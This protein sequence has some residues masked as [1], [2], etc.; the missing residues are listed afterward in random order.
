MPVH[1]RSIT[2]K[3]DYEVE[4]VIR[5]LVVA[6]NRQ[7]AD[8]SVIVEEVRP[9][10]TQLATTVGS[11]G[12]LARVSKVQSDQITSIITQVEIN[13]LLSY[14]RA[15]VN[16]TFEEPFDAVVTSD[17]AT[18]TMSIEQ[19]GGGD[20]NMQFSDGITAFDTTPPATIALTTGSD[21]SPTENYI[22]IPQS[23]KV[24]T[25]STSDWPTAEH[26]KVGF[27]LV[28]S[29]GFVQTNGVYIN[30]NWNDPIKGTTEQGHITHMAERSR[31]LG[32]VY[33]SG[34]AGNG[35]DGYLTPAAGNTE[36]LATAGE[37][38]Q[39]H[40]HTV[41]AFDTSGGDQVLVKNWN[42]DAYH[43]I[44]NLFDI[45]ADSTGAAIGNNKYFNLVIW[46]VAN[47]SGEY[48]PM[49]INL[50]AGSYNTQSG[51]EN[52][53]SGFDDFS[54]PGSFD[55]ESSTGFLIARITIQMGATWSVVSTVDLR[56]SNPQSASGGASGVSTEFADNTFKIFDEGDV[57]KIIQF[58]ASGITAG[59]TRTATMPD[60]DITLVDDAVVL[61]KDGSVALTAPWDAGA[62]EIRAE[63]FESDVATGTPPFVVA[64]TT[65]VSNLNVDLLDGLEETA[66]ALLAGRAGGQT[67]IGGTGSGDDLVLQSTSHGTKG[68]IILEDA[69]LITF[70]ATGAILAFRDFV[71]DNNSVRDVFFVVRDYSPGNG[72]NGIGSRIVFQSINDAGARV[73]IGKFGAV[74][75][76]AAAGSE[77][78]DFIMQN[79]NAA[80][81]IRASHDRN[82]MIAG[83]P[84]PATGTA[85]IV[86][87][88]GTA[89][90]NMG[91]NTA[92]LYANDD[93]GTVFMYAIDDTNTAVQLSSHN[94]RLFDPDDAD[95][96]PW[97]Y[98]SKNSY[99]GVEVGV[100]VARLA[101]LVEQL[102]GEQIIHTRPLASY[103]DWV[104]DQEWNMRR[105]MTA[106]EQW[107]ANPVDPD[108]LTPRP[109]PP[110]PL[111]KFPPAW[112]R[113]RLVAKGRL[114]QPKAHQ[115][116]AELRA[117]KAHRL[118]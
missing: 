68:D 92:G 67:L 29:A 31:L 97:S 91:A 104:D 7:E 81:I 75:R 89:L 70:T 52:D 115:L 101:R 3:V 57:T 41:P 17:G 65:L 63:T 12:D 28:P 26:I 8:T 34:I 55:L 47:K 60:A 36:L 10:I 78:G 53:T 50:P 49:L 9:Q 30:Q 76:V 100:N 112:L 38:Y 2:G 21:A 83:A 103:R 20:L 113:S 48:T 56:G 111:V 79:R 86:F 40:K 6:S 51:A 106:Y 74:L 18:V 61:K 23:T 37:V 99:L 14:P 62:F 58:Q 59:N 32:A 25:K 84:E 109:A 117:W 42:G 69:S 82:V 114:N 93:G 118:H 94:F 54:I 33:H 66:F 77:E 27:F 45:V 46:A 72:A 80:D 1:L 44:T 64:S 102:T 71:A 73:N 24:L 35:T 90:D 110:L 39:M 85:G 96:F 22:Y 4:Q 95:P 105:A 98:Y 88:D 116:Q 5:D 15:G 16:G 11:L 108:D 19:Q 43:D 107:E 87:A 13:N